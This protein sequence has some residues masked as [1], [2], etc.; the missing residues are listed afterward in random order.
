M[1]IYQVVGWVTWNLFLAII[2]VIA[3]WALAECA[4]LLSVKQRLVPL[5]FWF[6][7]AAVWMLFLPNTCYL[8][9]EWRHFLLDDYW[10]D[11]RN[12]AS[13]DSGAKL[14]LAQ[15]GLFYA[16]YSGLGVLC[17]ALSI[18][19]VDRLLRLMKAPMPWLAVP[20]YLLASLGVYMGLVIRL[21][22][23][24]IVTRP[25]YVVGIILEALSHPLVLLTV[26][27]FAVLL[28]GLYWIADV[29]V[30]GFSSRVKRFRERSR[31]SA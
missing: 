27:S 8:L 24:D 6:P 7:L 17:F 23:W 9:T 14:Q 11:M 1:E 10:R 13:F 31:E 22:S 20:F 3:G 29:W 2:P 5:W 16:I 18:R 15:W 21:N 30:D 19:P 26:A 25:M 12:A 28:A 4:R